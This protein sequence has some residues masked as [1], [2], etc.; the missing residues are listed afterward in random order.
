MVGS[1]CLPSLLCTHKRI[2]TFPF[3]TSRGEHCCATLHISFHGLVGCQ[4]DAHSNCKQSSM[5]MSIRP[6]QTSSHSWTSQRE[7]SFM[8][9]VYQWF[10]PSADYADHS[11]Q[12]VQYMECVA[13]NVCFEV[14]SQSIPANVQWV[15][16]MR[17]KE[18]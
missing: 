3:P 4:F 17:T 12:T 8:F 10:S 1:R 9:S 14:L 13:A 11:A 7:M 16:V 5:S 2:N 15:P 6:Y 18:N